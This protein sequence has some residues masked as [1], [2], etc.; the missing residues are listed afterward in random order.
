MV[1]KSLKDQDSGRV[2]AGVVADV[3]VGV[4]VAGPDLGRQVGPRS[5][6]G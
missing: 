3:G 2:V 1:G 6:M 4:G 5:R